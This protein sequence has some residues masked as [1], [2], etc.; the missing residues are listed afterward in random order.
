MKTNLNELGK[1]YWNHLQETKPASRESCPPPE[2]L[3]LLV[4]SKMARG[5]RTK[6]L[7]HALHCAD[8]LNEIKAILEITEKANAFILDLERFV[9]DS[10][11]AKG[12]NAGRFARYL[13]WNYAS[14]A[15][16]IIL[17]VA[18]VAFSI[19]RVSS[20]P[21]YRGAA[22]PAIELVSPVNK[23]VSGTELKFV[24]KSLPRAK[25][26][27]VEVFDPALDLVWRSKSIEKNELSPPEE[28]VRGLRPEETYYWIVTGVLE[29]SDTVKSGMKPFSVKK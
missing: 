27:L 22:V 6:I 29:N 5:E 26:Y 9:E 3:L 16:L 8:C 18:I 19:L 1:F 4:R 7:N 24:W 23:T 28:I 15:S 20:R 25:H 10:D 11:Q 2:R 14:V 17:F 13:S 21:G 12:G